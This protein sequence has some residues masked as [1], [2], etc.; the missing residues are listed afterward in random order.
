MGLP[1]LVKAEEVTPE[2]P[3]ESPAAQNE[4]ATKGS[5][6]KEVV[7][8]KPQNNQ[9]IESVTQAEN[10]PSTQTVQET[11]SEVKTTPKTDPE[12]EELAEAVHE[13]E[14][15][16][17]KLEAE[18]QQDEA[19]KQ[20]LEKFIN[21]VHFE[22]LW[23][24]HYRYG[25]A[26]EDSGDLSAG[27]DNY[28]RFNIGRGYL[29]MKFKPLKWFEGRVTMDTHQ[30]EEGDMKVRLKYL[31]G[32]FIAPVE[33]KVVSEPYAEFGLA[34]MPW[35]DYEEH[36]NWYRAQGTMFMERNKL[37]NSADFGLS[38]GVL[39]G[40]KLRGEYVE[41]VNSKYPGSFGSLAL[42]MYNGGG[43]HADE[44]NE[45]KPFEARVSIRP[46]GPFFPNPQLSYFV[47]LGKGNVEETSDWKPPKWQSH[48]MMASFEH[49][50]FTATGQF[51]TGEGNQ[52]GSFVDWTTTQDP[53]TGDDVKTGI[54]DVH[55]YN[56]ASG[57]LE[58]KVPQV[59]SSLIGRYDWFD[60]KDQTDLAKHRII[61][62]YAFHFYKMHKNFLMLDFD[63]TIP[64]DSIDDA[65]DAWEVKLTLQ[66][67]I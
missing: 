36:I 46:L 62:G 17:E 10:A 7:E 28:N 21:M 57:F 54:D 58:I 40:E 50:Y 3:A 60:K 33:S 4:T 1:A 56:G 53:V 45:N 34:H 67:K 59:K 64:D 20:K 24:L 63:Y 13:L 47:I 55:E 43:Y 22:T 27:Y 39:L 11:E 35:L 32:K 26:P 51:V 5:D 14:A 8:V 41:K 48:T 12:K 37:F 31:Y 66:I 65:K 25:Y 19:S 15:K 44:K 23:Y 61:A 16:V 29:T 49:E 9:E 30:D 52:K 18:S 42:G 38:V 6:T 2:T